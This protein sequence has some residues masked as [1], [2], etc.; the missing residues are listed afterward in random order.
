MPHTPESQAALTPAEALQLLRE[1]N[2]RFL[3]QKPLRRVHA[4]EVAAT[5][6][7]QW[8]FA[9]ILGCIDSRVPSELVFDLGFGDV[10]NVR[11][12]GNV[13]N[14][15]VLGSIEFACKVAGAK[16]IVVLGHSSC[17]AVKG[18]CDSVEL[19]HLGA[20]L[21][22][23]RPAVKAVTEPSDESQRSSSN[24]AFVQA[25]ADENVRRAVAAI[26]EQSSVIDALVESGTVGLVG[27]MY[28]VGEG[29]VRFHE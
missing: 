6:G 14:G 5:E 16:L 26:R 19:G 27:A 21:G 24:D 25:V 18:A 15:D 22:R 10:F 1:G 4:D 9:V 8:P 28:D 23:I 17:G 2:E 20:L 3:S 29:R 12:A 7:G 11:V 13:I